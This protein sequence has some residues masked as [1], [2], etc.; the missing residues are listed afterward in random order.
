MKIDSVA[1][2]GARALPGGL[3]VL[4][5]LGQARPALGQTW[6]PGPGNL[7]QSRHY[8]ATERGN[9]AQARINNWDLC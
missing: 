1:S 8:S 7:G 4:P 9:L 5:G 2:G 6:E 3:G